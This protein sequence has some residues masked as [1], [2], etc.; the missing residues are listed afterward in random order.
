MP[1][2]PNQVEK[3]L[4]NK[5]KMDR[6]NKNDPH[7]WYKLNIFGY[8]SISTKVSSNHTADITDTILSKMAKQLHV[9]SKVFR[10]LVDCSVSRE[11]YLR[12]IGYNE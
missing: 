3:M 12:I 1:Y 9:T 2:K 7:G 5:I 11:E 10:G 4:A 8:P 6:V